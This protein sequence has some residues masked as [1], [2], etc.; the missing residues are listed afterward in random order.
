M[1]LTSKSL[2]KFWISKIIEYVYTI[3]GLKIDPLPN[4]SYLILMNS[5][6]N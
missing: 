2:I 6:N 5:K 4:Y 1:E 3:E